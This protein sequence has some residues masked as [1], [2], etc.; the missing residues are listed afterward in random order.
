MNNLKLG[1]I[2][3][4]SL[5]LL[6]SSYVK[7]TVQG[8]NHPD[9]GFSDFSASTV[10]NVTDMS[11]SGIQDKIDEAS[12][13]GGGTVTLPKG[14]INI[15]SSIQMKSNVKL[16]GTL[17]NDSSKATTLFCNSND[18]TEGVISAMSNVINTTVENIII[19]V[20]E[21]DVHGISY[22][23]GPDNF[24]I[25]NNEIKNVGLTKVD[26]IKDSGRADNPTGINIWSNS[27]TSNNFTVKNNTIYNLAKHGI[28]VN[29]GKK[30]IL[31]DNS[32]DNAFMGIDASTGSA[33]GEILN[34]NITNCLFGLKIVNAQ[35]IDL[36]DNSIYSLDDSKWW[37]KWEDEWATDAGVSLILQEAGSNLSNIIVKD[38][39]L[40]P[41]EGKSQWVFWGVKDH[42]VIT[43]TNNSKTPPSG[44][45][46]K[47][48]FV[49]NITSCSPIV[50]FT[51][52]SSKSITTYSWKFGDGNTSTE[53]SPSYTYT[54]PGTYTVELTVSDGTN[55]DAKSK[56][57]T[58]NF[59]ETPT[60][61]KAEEQG[62]G[63]V[64]LTA[65][66]SGTINWYD[67]VTGG[68]PIATGNSVMAITSSTEFYVENITGGETIYIGGKK[69]KSS[70]NYYEWKDEDAIWGLEFNALEDII[71]KSVKVYNG[72]SKNGGY[73]GER[74]IKVVNSSG[75]TVA[76]KTVNI[77]DGE[78]RLVL[79]LQIPVGNGYR[80]LADNNVGFWRDN[81]ASEIIYPYSIGSVCT[82]TGDTRYDGGGS[83]NT[84][85]Y[86]FFYDLEVSTGTVG[87]TSER[88]K[89]DLITTAD[90]DANSNI[91][92]YP[93]PAKDYINISNLPKE[94][95]AVD[96]YNINIQQVKMLQSNGYNN[97]KIESSE[98]SSGVYFCKVL[99]KTGLVITKKIIIVK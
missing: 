8:V 87:C 5:V 30:F 54:E 75:T 49:L 18:V 43:F 4:V 3:I 64:L 51:N 74:T 60:N 31:Q 68:T 41:T 58:V 19:D 94:N 52:T 66:G 56:D 7:A 12:S 50:L 99:T 27:N 85:N 17:N 21:V 70:G 71:L 98:L 79:N 65:E 20:N 62:A 97:L 32:I 1:Q 48:D 10:Y 26:K 80:L 25:Y 61:V 63:T 92:I 59:A 76:E 24:L 37:D 16:K 55:S 69:D 39:I 15:T 2:L 38:N 57:I 73:T 84:D 14:V 67:V 81:V 91:T 9:W 46:V 83:V 28:D 72:A 90:E 13:N 23:Y 93:N 95:C 22:A 42:S 89:V 40:S 82:I 86:H 47:A 36:H 35:N 96:L 78:Q 88:V 44:N 77:V 11:G 53:K 6:I 34:N 29:Y 33:D 45:E